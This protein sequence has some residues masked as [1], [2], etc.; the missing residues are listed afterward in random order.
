[1]LALVVIAV[2]HSDSIDVMPLIWTAGLF[3]AALVLLVGRKLRRG[4]PY[5]VLRSAMWVVALDGDFLE[6][7]AGSPVTLGARV[8]YVAGTPLSILGA[9]LLV[10]SLSRGRLQPTAGWRAAAGAGASAGV[11]CSEPDG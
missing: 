2:V 1:L 4:P 11:G 10:T 8:G 6:R 5:F 3:A 9:A 7:V